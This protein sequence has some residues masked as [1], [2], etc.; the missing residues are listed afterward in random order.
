MNETEKAFGDIT[1]VI[2]MTKI[3]SFYPEDTVIT[4]LITKHSKNDLN[5]DQSQ[6]DLLKTVIQFLNQ[7]N[8]PFYTSNHEFITIVAQSLSDQIRNKFQIG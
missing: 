3:T 7:I 5:L 4:K 8:S 6:L 2:S 1:P